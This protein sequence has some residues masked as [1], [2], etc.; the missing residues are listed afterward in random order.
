MESPYLKTPEKTPFT[1]FYDTYEKGYFSNMA[2]GGH[3]GFMQIRQVAQGCS[4]GNKA[5]FDL[6][7][8]WSMNQ[9]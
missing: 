6:G 5:K 3:L 1:T 7:P 4:F 8:L 2:T 9:Q